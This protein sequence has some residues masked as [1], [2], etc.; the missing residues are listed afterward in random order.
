MDAVVAVIGQISDLLGRLDEQTVRDLVAGRRVLTLAEKPE[1]PEK[2][3]KTLPAETAGRSAAPP[4]GPAPPGRRRGA[5]AANGGLP[6]DPAEVR[7]RLEAMATRDE[8]ST[9]LAGLA[10]NK[11][12][13]QA[14]GEGLGV[15]ISRSKR[16]G[17]MISL[18][19]G[20]TVGVRLDQRS[21]RDGLISP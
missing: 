16:R 10:P 14:I 12:V 18:I 3:E 20:S 19:V 5:R 1:K 21:I 13:L 6:P 9:Y 7:R 4:D 2:P 15:S 17:E 11:D 8:A